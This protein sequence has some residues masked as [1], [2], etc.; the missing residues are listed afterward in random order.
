MHLLKFNREAKTLTEVP[1]SKFGADS[2]C[3]YFYVQDK[4][5]IVFIST[6][7]CIGEIVWQHPDYQPPS[8]ANYHT[9]STQA[10]WRI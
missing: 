3:R 8:P 6:P 7:D 5:V 2:D 4:H 9:S 1:P 10:T